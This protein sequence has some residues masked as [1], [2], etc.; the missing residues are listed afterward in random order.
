MLEAVPMAVAALLL[1]WF[2]LVLFRKPIRGVLGRIRGV[3]PLRLSTGS[4]QQ[5]QARDVTP[6]TT[7]EILRE[8]FDNKLVAE[9]ED[10]F[11]KTLDES[12]TD[13]A[14]REIVLLRHLAEK[15][16]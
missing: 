13:P 5:K 11:R 16:R 4:G 8:T 1:G 14:A 6:N 12:T 3:G 9:T 10:Q 7:E 2:F 15:H